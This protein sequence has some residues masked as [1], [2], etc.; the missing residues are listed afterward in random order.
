MTK[1]E[2]ELIRE[3]LTWVNEEAPES[4]LILTKGI[5]QQLNDFQKKN[6]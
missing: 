6:A 3:L 5:D 1:K 4:A 2:Q